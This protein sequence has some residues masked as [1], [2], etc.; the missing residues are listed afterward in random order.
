MCVYTHNVNGFDA[1]LQ[2][3]IDHSVLCIVIYVNR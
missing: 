1:A 2:N 3:E